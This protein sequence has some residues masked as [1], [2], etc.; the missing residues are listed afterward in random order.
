MRKDMQSPGE[1]K[2][3]EFQEKET[4]SVQPYDDS[5]L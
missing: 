5:R 4:L 2:K 1:K 3:D